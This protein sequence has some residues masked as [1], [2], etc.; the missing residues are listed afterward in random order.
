MSDATVD[1][2]DKGLVGASLRTRFGSGADIRLLAVFSVKASATTLFVD[3]E[4]AGCV[5][6]RRRFD[7]EGD[8]LRDREA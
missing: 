4:A 6:D 8:R 5:V 7:T 1:F 3:C 2:V